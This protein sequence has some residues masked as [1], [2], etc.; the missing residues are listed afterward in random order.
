MKKSLAAVGGTL[1]L[2]C[3]LLLGCAGGKGTAVGAGGGKKHVMSEEEAFFT[4]LTLEIRVA[5][6]ASGAN[7][8]YDIT[9]SKLVVMMDDSTGRPPKLMHEEYLTQEQEAALRK[10]VAELPLGKLKN[11]YETPG[12]IDG[13]YIEFRIPDGPSNQRIIRVLN[14]YQPDLVR[15]AACVDSLLPEKLRINYTRE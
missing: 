3:G 2:L 15:L 11:W 12:V 10:C 7:L 6:L 4:R 13:A 1:F 8:W 5:E 9:G 14:Y